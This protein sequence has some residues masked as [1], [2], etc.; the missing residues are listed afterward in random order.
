MEAPTELMSDNVITLPNKATQVQ[1]PHRILT[2]HQLN[3][4]NARS[5]IFGLVQLSL[6]LTIMGC[7]GYLWTTNH[8][9]FVAIPA[10]FIYGFSI[11]SMF[12]PMHEAVHRT[13]FASLNL[14]KIVAWFTGVLSFY[15]STFFRYYHKWHHLYTRVPGK[16]PELTDRTPSNFREYLVILSGFLWWKGKIQGHF[17]IAQGK[18]EDYPFIPESAGAEV[19][20]S[21]RLQLTIYIVALGISLFYGQPWFFIY[22]LLP[23]MVGQPILRFIL[24][25][26]HTGCTRDANLLTNTRTTRTLIPTQFLMWNMSFHAEHHLYPSIP[27]HALPKSHNYLDTHFT[28]IDPGYFK[29]NQHI[30]TKLGH[31]P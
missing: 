5:N 24:L 21:T 14:N 2:K 8:N 7:S 18:I 28:H 4:L 15:N 20:R 22:W 25:A 13:A 6:H 29:V 9:L 11:A 19:I 12:A 1:N 17:R 3:E 26:E 31:L 16:D 10:L 30:V 27:F 23:L